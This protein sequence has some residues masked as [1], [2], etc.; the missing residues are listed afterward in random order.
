MPPLIDTNDVLLKEQSGDV[1]EVTPP[2]TT[3]IDSQEATTPHG[4][5]KS[6]AIKA[7]LQEIKNPVRKYPWGPNHRP[8]ISESLTEIRKS[9]NEM[10]MHTGPKKNVEHA[11]SVYASLTPENKI[12][13][14]PG[15]IN[16]PHDPLK[17]VQHEFHEVR[18]KAL[19]QKPQ[20]TK[21]PEHDWDKNVI[22]QLRYYKPGFLVIS[23][24]Q[25]NATAD[26]FIY[27]LPDDPQV[28]TEATENNLL[29]GGFDMIEAF[30]TITPG[31]PSVKEELIDDLLP[32][33]E[34]TEDER[35]QYQE[36]FV[37]ALRSWYERQFDWDDPMHS[38]LSTKAESFQKRGLENLPVTLPVGF[39]LSK[40]VGLLPAVVAAQLLPMAPKLVPLLA[41]VP[42]YANKI[43]PGEYRDA[44]FR[45]ANRSVMGKVRQKALDRAEN[46]AI[47]APEIK[48]WA[49][50]RPIAFR[51]HT[52]LTDFR[53]ALKSL[54]TDEA[55][56][57]LAGQGITPEGMTIMLIPHYDAKADFNLHDSD[58][59]QEKVIRK[60]L[61]TFFTSLDQA[62]SAEAQE[63]PDPVREEM[64]E[65]AVKIFS[66]ESVWQIH[67]QLKT[68]T[69][70]GTSAASSESPE[71][72]TT[73][74]Q[75]ISPK[76]SS[77]VQEIA[78]EYA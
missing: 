9:L 37:T 21:A 43:L 76:I 53:R 69:D 59:D 64:I 1:V 25:P 31:K 33:S 72:I 42:K 20:E 68:S 62:S 77:L 75:E 27:E 51:P 16:N 56:L 73:V 39:A 54:K 32:F 34:S 40:T 45:R 19:R 29:V 57:A 11:T 36:I 55:R 13:I 28:L 8:F 58:L 23:G 17:R 4:I 78:E 12:N 2:L 60:G 5:L 66:S 63:L 3:I 65:A 14:L 10:F 15:S 50:R 26:E 48:L 6:D 49:K 7:S 61:Q 24:L 70:I 71:T 35:T 52:E 47:I 18:R 44:A 41:A 46:H 22:T 30:D 74:Y 38:S 67:N